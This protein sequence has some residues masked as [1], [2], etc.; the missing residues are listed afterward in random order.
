MPVGHQSERR[1]SA[2]RVTDSRHLRVPRSAARVAAIGTWQAPKSTQKRCLVG[3]NSQHPRALQSATKDRQSWYPLR[4]WS[5]K[6]NGTPGSANYHQ[7][8]APTD[9][10][11]FKA[12]G[13]G[14]HLPSP[15]WLVASQRSNR[16][17]YRG[18]LS[19]GAQGGP[20]LRLGAAG[21]LCA[22][23]SRGGNRAARHASGHNW[24]DYT[25]IV[26]MGAHVC[27]C[28]DAM[29]RQVTRHVRIRIVM[30]RLF[31]SEH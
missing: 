26:G 15:G 16:W 28:H 19:F 20:G 23:G 21:R 1:E 29:T 2:S 31:G 14:M 4:P 24:S 27:P 9:A 17:R 12:A 3:A 30:S 10:W 11:F 25:A 5:S 18:G 7:A 8:P 6:K 22:G 13:D